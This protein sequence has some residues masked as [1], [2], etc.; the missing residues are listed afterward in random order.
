VLKGLLGVL[1]LFLLP[2]LAADDNGLGGT[3]Q[4]ADGPTSYTRLLV[5]DETNVTSTT[6]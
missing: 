1:A 5:K 4:G 3:W 6:T 2:A